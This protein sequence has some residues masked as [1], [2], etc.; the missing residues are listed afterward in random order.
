[1]QR[2]A[3][4]VTDEASIAAALARISAQT[5][6]L[7]LV[8]ACAG[9]LHDEATGIRPE[10]RLADVD[11][12]HLA[13]SFT[14]NDTGPLLLLKHCEPLLTRGGHAV[15]A[16]LSPRIGSIGDNRFG[17][18]YA[19]RTAKA[20]QNQFTRTASIE[21]RRKSKQAICVGL[22]PGTTDT[23]LSRLFQRN[24]PAGKLFTPA[25]AA[26]CLLSVLD[27]LAPADSGGVFAWDGQR[28]PD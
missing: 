24:V 8:I 23:A 22:H 3:L 14:V 9:L 15:F 1:M 6:R 4:D 5:E 2:L 18:W 19:Y 21:L 28:I 12:G 27:G 11:P 13:R 16:S 25:F 20:A 26:G 10:K 17:G 7:D